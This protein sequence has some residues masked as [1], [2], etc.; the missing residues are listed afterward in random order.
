M[1]GAQVGDVK[2]DVTLRGVILVAG[3]RG[4]AAV[5]RAATSFRRFLLI[6]VRRSRVNSR[7]S[8]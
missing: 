8:A 3:L 1:V 4:E 2:Q 7:M 5:W 6:P